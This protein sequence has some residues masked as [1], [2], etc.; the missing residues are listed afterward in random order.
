MMTAISL[1]PSP[2][3]GNNI[4]G[5]GLTGASGCAQLDIKVPSNRHSASRSGLK[6]NVLLW[7]FMHYLAFAAIG[8]GKLD[9]Y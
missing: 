6:I 7:C 1:A 8:E 2:A 3:A 5:V 4:F 9:R